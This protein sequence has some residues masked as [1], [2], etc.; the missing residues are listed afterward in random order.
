MLPLAHAA[1]CALARLGLTS[2]R[3]G[4]RSLPSESPV[5]PGAWAAPGWLPYR[6][7]DCSSLIQVQLL[8]LQHYSIHLRES[9]NLVAVFDVFTNGDEKVKLFCLFDNYVFIVF[10]ELS[11]FVLIAYTDKSGLL[12]I[13][14]L[15]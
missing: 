15:L 7:R 3:L 6:P 4:K 2:S 11:T 14:I 10:N 13:E 9:A 12:V 8:R 5:L 1:S